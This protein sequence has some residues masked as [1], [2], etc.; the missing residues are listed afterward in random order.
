MLGTVKRIV[1]TGWFN[2][3]VYTANQDKL[4]PARRQDHRST[5]VG[6]VR[7]FNGL[8]RA[9][10]KLFCSHVDVSHI[11]RKSFTFGISGSVKASGQLTPATAG[12]D[13]GGGVAV[14]TASID[15]ADMAGNIK[16]CSS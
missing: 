6:N 2:T 10:R 14:R 1:W 12:D 7:C 16:S 13:D 15:K 9:T 5:Q 3:V 8:V 11:D 4:Y